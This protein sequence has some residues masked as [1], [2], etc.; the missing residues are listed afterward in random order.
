MHVG[1][2][3]T[4]HDAVVAVD[5]LEPLQPVVPRLD[6]EPEAEQHRA[7]RHRHRSDEAAL[8]IDRNRAVHPIERRGHQTGDAER[9]QQPVLDRNISGQRE[10]IESDVLAE[11]GIGEAVRHLIDVAQRHAPIAELRGRNQNSHDHR[12]SGDQPAPGEVAIEPFEQ[13][14]RRQTLDRRPRRS[15]AV[16]R[17][18]ETGQL[19]GDG[20]VDVKDQS[21]RDQHRH[22]HRDLGGDRG[23]KHAGKAERGE[24]APIDQEASGQA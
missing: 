5:E 1:E 24:P 7:V 14:R 18:A 2:T 8:L 22:E 4:D 6:D 10:Q 17:G 12:R 23:P 13:N 11:Q 16:Q 9:E 21:R 15:D 20:G 19:L 3:G